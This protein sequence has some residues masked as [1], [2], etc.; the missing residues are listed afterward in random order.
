ML[1]DL[2]WWVI[3]FALLF[4]LF[5]FLTGLIKAFK[6]KNMNSVTMRAGLFHK[7]G[8]I[9]TIVLAI[10]CE[11]AIRHVDLS[12]NMPLV[13]PVC[14]YIVLTELTSVL[15]NLT[16]I[17]PELKSAPIFKLFENSESDGK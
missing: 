11:G 13:I 16:E 2:D 9:L 7:V 10:L 8:F 12:F 6:N 4:I 1:G 14:S 5:D 15:E 17:A 3:V